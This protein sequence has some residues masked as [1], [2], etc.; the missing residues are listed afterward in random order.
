M[1]QSSKTLIKKQPRKLWYLIHDLEMYNYLFFYLIRAIKSVVRAALK[2][3]R[4]QS[5][6]VENHKNSEVYLLHG[7]CMIKLYAIYTTRCPDFDIF[8]WGE[9]AVICS[10]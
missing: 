3:A 1:L 2:C 6:E 9:E 8:L 4:V 7:S 10:S 5:I